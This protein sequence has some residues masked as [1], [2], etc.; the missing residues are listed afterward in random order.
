MQPPGPL[1]GVAKT[2]LG[3]ARAR[4]RESRREDRL[5]G[6]PYAQAFVEAAP[7]V[8]PQEPATWQ[9]RAALGP[10]APLGAAFHAHAVIRTRF[11]DDY[12]AGAAGAGCRQVVL[13]AAGLDTR[14]FR[15]AWPAGVRLFEVDLP[16]VLAFKEPVLA[17]CGAVPR[18]QPPRRR[19][20]R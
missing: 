6:D 1:P 3:V 2:A 14:A 16:G 20:P 12:L 13:L 5:F 18:C 8:F 15:L 19:F 4:A 10:L 9:Q 7:G 11:F 17:A